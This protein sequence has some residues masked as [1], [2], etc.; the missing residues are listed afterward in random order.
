M[1]L[2]TL[3]PRPS[4]DQPGLHALLEA[5]EAG[6][7][8]A[9]PFGVVRMDQANRVAAYSAAESRTSGLRPETV[10]GRDFFL[11]VAPCMNNFLVALRFETEV[12]LDETVDFVLT[13]RMRPTPAR[14]RLLASRLHAHR[15]VLIERTALA[16]R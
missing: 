5:A 3:D 16:G 4:F 8:D 10:L 11:D 2:A 1:C 7:L 9:L 15:Y 12:E 14:L 6:A 13:F